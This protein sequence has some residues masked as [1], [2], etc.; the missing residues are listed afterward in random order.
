MDSFDL[1]FKQLAI[2]EPALRQEI[3][4]HASITSHKNKEQIIRTGEYIKVLK[5]LLK[6]RIRVFQENEDR[7]ILIYYLAPLET[8]TLS[9]SACFGDCQST[10][11][12]IVEEEALVLNI[13]VQ[14][15][16][17]WGNQYPSW[18]NFTI[19]TF[20]HSYNV[21]MDN[22]AQLAFKTLNERLLEY[23]LNNAHQQGNDILA[24]SHQQ[25]A[26]E[27]GT[28]REVVS[29]LL[30]KLE[31]EQRIKLGQKSIQVIQ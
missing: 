2:H 6:G 21:L 16:R 20:R 8:C 14:Y 29:R 1:F 4:Q 7:E 26:N 19:N 25:I 23:L 12:A 15:V 24:M 18:N 10:V 13:P 22:Y 28:T 30:K 9:L 31:K 3:R 27:L 11:N 17:D 5:I